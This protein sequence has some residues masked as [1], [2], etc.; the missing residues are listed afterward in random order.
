MKAMF[1]IK[2]FEDYIE[3]LQKA[4]KDI[5]LVSRDALRESGEMLQ[6]AIIARVPVDTGNLKDHIKIKT[7][8]VEGH[9]N[10]VEVG[11]IHDAAYTDKETMIGAIAVEFGSTRMAARPYVRPA[12]SS[13][14]AAV[15]RLI[16]QRLKA[17]GLVD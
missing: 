3:A 13:K 10:Y 4:G 16:Q 2:G 11:V 5:D 9:Y 6:A 15:K 1:D 14:K 8:S 7:P 12:I 17:A